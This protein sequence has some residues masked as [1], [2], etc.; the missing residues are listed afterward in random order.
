MNL[1]LPHNA[2]NTDDENFD[3]SFNLNTSLA[4]DTAYITENFCDDWVL[5]LG[6]EDRVSLGLF[7]CFQARNVLS[8]G[9][10]KAAEHAALMIGRNEKTTREWR[11]KFF[12]N[13]GRIIQSKQGS[14]QRSG[15]LW[16]D[17]HFNKK[18]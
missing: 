11:A 12:E 10:T 18:A 13:D 7:I 5:T 3:S 17:D 16:S 9:E 8:F 15:I 6:Q 4:S 2:L 1:Q 14:Y